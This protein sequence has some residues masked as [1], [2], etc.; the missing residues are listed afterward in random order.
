MSFLGGIGSWV[1]NALTDPGQIVK[2]ASD[3][4]LPKNLA[5]VGDAA[6]AYGDV[7]TG[8]EAQAI[9]HGVDALE[10]LPQLFGGGGLR[11]GGSG[12]LLGGI[13]GGGSGSSGG[14]GLL[15]G[16]LGGGSGGGGFLGGSAH[17]LD[18]AGLFSGLLRG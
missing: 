2:D 13:L 14:G 6:A 11:S 8:H 7:E 15:G 10:D 18:P 1:Q 12:G 9:G 17:I 16:V 4:V 5:V 3:E